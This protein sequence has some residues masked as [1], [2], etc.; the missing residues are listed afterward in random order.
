ML[1]RFRVLDSMHGHESPALNPLLEE[2]AG[3]HNAVDT[4]CGDGAYLSRDNYTQVA[5]LGGVPRFYPR[6]DST[7]NSKGSKPYQDML[8]SFIQ[9]PQA[10]LEEYHKRCMSETVF[11]S[12]KRRF[13]TP[14]RRK[15]KTRRKLEIITRICVYN[16]TQL[17]YAT[18]TK[19]LQTPLKTKN[20]TKMSHSPF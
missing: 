17:S 3:R 10:W 5:A 19:N 13:H 9:D 7:L 8:L 2:L 4:V 20:Q 12:L 1:S 14:L 11:S 16:L 15:I 6:K 18:W